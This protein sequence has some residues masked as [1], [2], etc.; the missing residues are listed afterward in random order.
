L[1]I[2]IS[3][4]NKKKF[5]IADNLKNLRKYKEITLEQ[6]AKNISINFDTARN[7]EQD[8]IIPP[9]ENL[10]KLASFFEISL[11]FLLLWNNTPYTHNLKF[12]NNAKIIDKLNINERIKIEGPISS[13]LNNSTED[14]KIKMDNN[15]I[16]VSNNISENIKKLRLKTGLTQ[17]QISEHL[18]I[19]ANQVA[20]YEN[21]KSIP[22]ADKLIK[23]SE[24]F[25]I[26]IHALVT[27]ELLYYSFENKSLLESVI[28]ADKVLTFEHQKFLIT[29]M[30]TII[31]NSQS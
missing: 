17:K 10:T 12:L 11:D 4:F 20:F 31:K 6:L 19:S 21:N 15:S 2:E 26:S 22:P 27:G 23:L 29:L 7:Y 9:L 8:N 13:F 1:S 18:N 28:K 24:L 3:K 25:S 30:E 16:E 5:S 14:I